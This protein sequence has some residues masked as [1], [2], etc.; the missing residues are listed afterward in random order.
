MLSTACLLL[1]CRIN[2]RICAALRRSPWNNYWGHASFLCEVVVADRVI[3]IIRSGTRDMRLRTTITLLTLLITVGCSRNAATHST[4]LLSRSAFRD[5]YISELRHQ[6]SGIS[7]QAKEDL[8][9]QISLGDQ[10]HA[11]FLD[12]AYQEYCFAPDDLADVLERYAHAA[13]ETL[14]MTDLDLFDSQ[15]VVPV[16]KDSRYVIDVKQSMINA[17]QDV[18]KCDLYYEVV[19]PDLHVLYAEDTEYNI[20]YLGGEDVKQLGMTAPELRSNAVANL[21]QILPPIEKR[22]TNGFYMVTAGGTYEASLL[23]LDSIWSPSN[24]V[25]NGEIVVGIPSRDLLFV[26]GS[27]DGPNIKR[28]RKV[29]EEAVAESSYALTATLFVKTGQG[30]NKLE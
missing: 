21:K 26:T 23:L 22:G 9:L 12:N 14:K 3:T 4:P 10:E 24:F 18:S 8:E 19:N 28:L 25:V 20:R 15:R 27:E 17:G 16:I 13:I 6:D 11:A 5:S 30:W 29:C 2:V 1:S 7:V